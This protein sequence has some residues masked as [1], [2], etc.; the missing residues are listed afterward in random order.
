MCH[1]IG[2]GLEIVS[3]GC[4]RLSTARMIG[5]IYLIDLAASTIPLCFIADTSK[6]QV[7]RSGKLTSDINEL[8]DL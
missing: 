6:R 7:A 4:K 1:F 5:T 8:H 2:G 3:K